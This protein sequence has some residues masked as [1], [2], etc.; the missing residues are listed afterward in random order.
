VIFVHVLPCLRVLQPKV[1][2]VGE[3]DVLMAVTVVQGDGLVL[4]K[5]VRYRESR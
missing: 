2:E 3:E 5:H 1:L 4:D